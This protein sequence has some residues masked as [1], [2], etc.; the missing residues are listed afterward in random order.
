MSEYGRA[1]TTIRLSKEL[2]ALVHVLKSTCIGPY[3]DML[4]LV[5]AP[6]MEAGMAVPSPVKPGHPGQVEQPYIHS[7]V[8]VHEPPPVR[9]MSMST[10]ST[11]GSVELPTQ[12]RAH[13]P[14][15]SQSAGTFMSSQVMS[16]SLSSG[17]LQKQALPHHTSSPTVTM[18]VQC[19]RSL[20]TATIFFCRDN[21]L[22]GRRMAKPLATLGT[23]KS[24][25]GCP[26]QEC[27]AKGR[28]Y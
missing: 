28:F 20:Q 21:F 13:E 5:Q 19:T 26:W 22:Y 1:S 23:R 3:A 8:A 18:T 10:A 11:S 16:A 27:S 24:W 9:N 6:Q 25:E 4:W 2:I 7:P 14:D 17:M 15:A 12:A